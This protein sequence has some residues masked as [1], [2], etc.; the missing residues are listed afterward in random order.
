[1]DGAAAAAADMPRFEGRRILVAD[2]SAVNR[3][4][5]IEALSRLGASAAMV[6][7]GVKA[8][9]A[10]AND[11]TLDLILMDGSMPEMDGFEASRA[12]RED[13]RRTGRTRIP[14]V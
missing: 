6:V 14:I 9:E 4:V 11:P 1:M 3:E 5:A 13:E 2:D 7:D 12:I 8:V 10:A